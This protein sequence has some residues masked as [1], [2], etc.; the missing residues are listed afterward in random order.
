MDSTNNL[1]LKDVAKNMATP[2]E[3]PTV[4]DN[5]PE[6][7]IPEAPTAQNT[8][9]DDDI[10]V[11][12]A[13]NVT[14]RPAAADPTK[15]MMNT[16]TPSAVG[17]DADVLASPNTIPI[18]TNGYKATSED[19]DMLEQIMPELTIE[20]RLEI[21]KPI[22]DKTPEI[23]KELIMSGFTIEDASV[24]AKNRIKKEITEAYED[25]K[26]EKLDAT[27][28][29]V[30]GEV[31]IDKTADPNG[32]GLTEEEHKKLEK[33]K[34]VRL[35]VVEDTDLSNI[36]IERPKEEFKA[37][38]IK[39]IEG[40]LA[41]YSVPMPMLGDFVNFKG[42]QLVQMVN[43]VN[44]DDAKV[45]EIIATKASLIYEK[46][47]GGSVLQ[48]YD[49]TGKIIMSYQEFANKFPFH[50][51]DMALYAILCASSTEENSTSLTCQACSHQWMQNYNLKSLLRM[52]NVPEAFKERI[53]SILK[54]KGN[55]IKMRDLFE[56]MRKAKRFKSPFSSNIYDL[57]YPTVARAV[58]LMKRID[59]EDAV[60]AYLSAIGVFVSRI[61]IFN[62]NK[63]TYIE[64]T[65]EETDL[66]LET[67]AT[68]SNEDV[69]MLAQQVR[70]TM[71]YTP[72]FILPATCPSCGKKSEIPVSIED[73]IFL[74]A[75]DSVVE[76]DS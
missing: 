62:P 47:I 50:D 9:V 66:M 71:Y 33:V 74:I 43:I 31:I 36:T 1:T 19:M 59:T 51:I 65:S 63:N 13:P 68:L 57:S 73:L 37:D 3:E 55:D 53:D 4:I 25:S 2:Q 21:A 16:P 27:G 40:S 75:R 18:N 70:E 11:I 64:I 48:K 35:I 23:K 24:A 28:D 54:N 32:L 5:S 30:S 52:D 14:A 34:K 17:L 39:S 61:L 29:D 22:L 8:V 60:M 72:E 58:N 15:M 10:P 44:Y 76:I 67:L 41:K 26:V 56:G 45:D 69:N 38:Y 42:A 49:S 6:S 20:R 12:I 46:L 7:E